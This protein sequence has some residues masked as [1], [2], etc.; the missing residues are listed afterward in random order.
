[1]LEAESKLVARDEPRPAVIPAVLYKLAAFIRRGFLDAASYRLNFAGTYFSGVMYVVF[2]ALLARFIG[3]TPLGVA[4]YGD[5]FTFLLIGSVFARYLSLGMKHLSRELEH[6][7]VMG[8][9]EPML[10]TAT[11]PALAI[12]GASAWILVEGV[13]VLAL[14]LAVGTFVFG[15]NLS[16]ANWPAALLIGA[17]T[18]GALNSWG[19]LS[20]SF[21]LLFKRADPL[22]WLIDLTAFIFC[23]VYFPVVFL[24]IWLRWISYLLP[25]TWG[26]EGLREALMRGR[27]PAELWLYALVLAGF[28]VLLIPLGILTFRRALARSK[29]S[30]NL[31]HY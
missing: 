20:A 17:L 10:V 27:A 15:A 3:Q 18:L 7:M 11:P 6:E 14:Q 31:G 4:A 12:L 19:L 5:Y 13:V 28:N 26:L 1:M 29:Q 24:P 25:L 16:A 30:G 9:I 22:N 2:Y 8:T 23:G 21:V